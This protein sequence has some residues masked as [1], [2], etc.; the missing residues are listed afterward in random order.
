[1]DGIRTFFLILFFRCFSDKGKTGVI[2]RRKAT[3]PQTLYAKADS[4]DAEGNSSF[5]EPDTISGW[6]ERAR[7]GCRSERFYLSKVIKAGEKDAK[8]FPMDHLAAGHD[9]DLRSSRNRE[10]RDP[11]LGCQ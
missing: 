2:R 7:S 8:R 5:I 4:R 11:G 9:A 6:I 1:M 3:G 10:N